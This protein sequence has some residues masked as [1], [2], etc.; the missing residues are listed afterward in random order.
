MAETG[1]TQSKLCH[2]MLRGLDLTCRWTDVFNKCKKI[3][4][5][6]DPSNHQKYARCIDDLQTTCVIPLFL[7]A[8][9]VRGVELCDPCMTCIRCMTPVTVATTYVTFSVGCCLHGAVVGRCS[10]NA[11][12][13]HCLNVCHG[14]LHMCVHDLGL[15]LLFSADMFRKHRKLQTVANEHRT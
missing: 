13:I 14:L 11:Y 1:E 2:A 7:Y 3:D 5:P 12:A 10:H 8:N 6:H 9:Y 15:P 4:R